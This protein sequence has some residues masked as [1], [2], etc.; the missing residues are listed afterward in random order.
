MVNREQIVTV[1]SRTKIRASNENEP[2]RSVQNKGRDVF[3]C[4]IAKH[5]HS[6]P[7]DSKLIFLCEF[8]KQ[9]ETFVELFIHPKLLMHVQSGVL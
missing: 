8:K 2:E 7:E 5:S 1:Y 4:H 9:P 6:L 3:I